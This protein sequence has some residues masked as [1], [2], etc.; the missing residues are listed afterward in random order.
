MKR[1]GQRYVQYVN[2]T[3]RRSGTLWEGRFRSCLTQED[4]YVLGCYRYIELNPVRAGMIEHPGEYQWSSYRA[5][6]QGEGCS[7]LNP[8]ECYW[9]LG[10]HGPARQTAYRELFRHQLDSGLVDEIRRATNGNYVLGSS[11]FQTQVAEA[12]GR[13]VV[14]G[15]PGRP[16]KE[17]DAIADELVGSSRK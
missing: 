10:A 16:K 7:V 4:S 12:L 3:Y 6:A 2:R 11:R 1:L 8:H 9:G 15:R 17:N 14:R 13:R 5:N